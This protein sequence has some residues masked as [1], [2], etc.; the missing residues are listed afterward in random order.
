MGP[1]PIL[2]MLRSRKDG[3]DIPSPPLLLKVLLAEGNE[4]MSATAKALMYLPDWARL[5]SSTSSSG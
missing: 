5:T 4:D 3:F 2:I 1:F